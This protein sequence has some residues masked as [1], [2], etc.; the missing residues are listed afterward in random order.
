MRSSWIFQEYYISLSAIDSTDGAQ[1]KQSTDLKNR[2]WGF[3]FVAGLESDWMLGWG[4]SLYGAADISIL[5]GFFDINQKG[6]QDGARIFDLDKSFRTG[7]AVMDL[8]MGLKWS[9]L[10]TTSA[11]A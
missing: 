5:L 11:S 6:K 2:F 4:V 3:G 10:S 9:N 1:V 8:D 7:R